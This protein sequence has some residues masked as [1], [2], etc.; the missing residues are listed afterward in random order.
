MALLSGDVRYS[1]FQAG[2]LCI[3]FKTSPYLKRYI[4]VSKW[5]SGYIECVAEY[6]TLSE[7]VEEYI[8]LRF[9]ADRLGL[10]S[11]VFKNIKEVVVK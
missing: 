3:K 4:C 10:S 8:D 11:D 7:P 1:V 6:S 9:I 2:E 5:D